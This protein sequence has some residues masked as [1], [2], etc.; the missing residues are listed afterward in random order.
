MRACVL[1]V[2]LGV[3]LVS[4]AAQTAR[5]DSFRY[6]AT[7]VVAPGYNDGFALLAGV[8]VGTRVVDYGD[9]GVGV[10]VGDLAYSDVAP[11]VMAQ[12]LAGMTVPIGSRSRARAQ[13]SG[14]VLAADRDTPAD[15]EGFG[16]RV[17]GAQTEAT[18][19]HTVPV[20]GSLSLVPTAGGYA[21]ACTTRNVIEQPGES[22]AEAG[23]LVGA[24]VLFKVFGVDAVLP[25]VV[26]IRVVGDTDAA[27]LNGAFGLAR[28]AISGGLQLWF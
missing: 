7:P 19:S 5:P 11:F 3:S 23:V 24:H 4:A 20:A 16:V 21:A 12:P 6:Y 10:Y 14:L 9:V 28:R 1:A 13:V 26:P 15:P 8:V 25:L 2:L 22:C 18:L 27:N 17:L